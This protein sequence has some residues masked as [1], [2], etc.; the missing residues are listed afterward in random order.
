MRISPV[1]S[2][3]FGKLMV[4]NKDNKTAETLRKIGNNPKIQLQL[5]DT[6]KMLNKSTGIDT[7]N[8]QAAEASDKYGAYG[9]HVLATLKLSQ[10]T[11]DFEKSVDIMDHDSA[12]DIVKR[13]KSLEELDGF[14]LSLKNFE[15]LAR[16]Y[17]I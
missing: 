14:N 7:L 4:L 8:F 11:S 6:F 13:I 1:N 16:K 5:Q 15:N 9:R 12:N 2:A 3:S 10:S 17:Q